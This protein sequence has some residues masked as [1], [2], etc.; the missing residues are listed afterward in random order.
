MQ[1]THTKTPVGVGA[2]RPRAA[3]IA[4]P[5]TVARSTESP[6]YAAPLTLAAIVILAELLAVTMAIVTAVG[7]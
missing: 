1:L 6:S 7:A 3:T 2:P 5:R 4:A